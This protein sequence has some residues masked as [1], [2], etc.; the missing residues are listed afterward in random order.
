MRAD[1]L[2]AASPVHARLI[3]TCTATRR[4]AGCG[5]GSG[6]PCTCGCA[7]ALQRAQIINIRVTELD[8][9]L[10]ETVVLGNCGRCGSLLIEQHSGGFPAQCPDCGC[11]W[12]REAEL[13]VVVRATCASPATLHLEQ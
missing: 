3:P 9:D 10:E 4:C 2:G 13:P 11:S 5:A 12:D 8:V 7:P 1:I 6:D